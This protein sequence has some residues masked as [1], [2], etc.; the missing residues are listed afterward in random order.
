MQKNQLQVFYLSNVN[1]DISKK[2]NSQF[3]KIVYKMKN[4]KKSNMKLNFLSILF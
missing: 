3:F 1:I 2:G 4:K